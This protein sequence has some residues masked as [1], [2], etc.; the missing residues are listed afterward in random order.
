[1]TITIDE[2][3]KEYKENFSDNPKVIFEIGAREAADSIKLKK[4]FPLSSVYAFEAHPIC[5]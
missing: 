5:Y 2:L 3:I 4:I 1:M